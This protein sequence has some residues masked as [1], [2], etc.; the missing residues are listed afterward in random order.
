MV[1]L[2]AVYKGEKTMKKILLFVFL[3]QA[4]YAGCSPAAE[5]DIHSVSAPETS[6][7]SET[8]ERSEVLESESDE[9]SENIICIYICGEVKSPGIYELP[10]GSRVFEA[11]DAAGG[12]LEGVDTTGINM[13]EKLSDGQQITVFKEGAR[14]EGDSGVSGGG[15]QKVNLNTADKEELMTLSGIGEARA[16]DIIEYR[17]QFGSFSSAEDIMNISGIGEKMYEKI[18]DDIEV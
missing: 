12:L 14:T 4:I 7:V 6:S 2:S 10:E 1:L 3:T 15:K 9:E 16:E 17:T 8:E 5:Y 13:S 18:K 11:V